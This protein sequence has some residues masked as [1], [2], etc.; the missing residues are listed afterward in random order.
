[1]SGILDLMQRARAASSLDDFGDDSFREGLERLVESAD[2]EARLTERG[3]MGFEMQIVDLL[4]NRLQVEHWYRLHPEIDQQQI[5][6]PLI[7]LGQIGRAHVCTPVTNAH[8]V[9]RLLL[10]KKKSPTR[11][12]RGN[13]AVTHQLNVG[14]AVTSQRKT[15]ASPEH[16]EKRNSIQKK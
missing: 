8:L 2:R 15:T 7:G 10:E 11:P 4:V 6:A 16:T 5:V 13:S 14:D 3:R 1:M 12:A 9:C